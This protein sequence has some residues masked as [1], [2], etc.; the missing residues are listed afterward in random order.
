MLNAFL[1]GGFATLLATP[2]SAPFVGTAIGF[3]LARGPVEIV[4]VFAVMGLGLAAPYLAVAAFPGLVRLMPKP[5]RWMI[6]LRR[7]L[8][9]ALAG[10]ASWL[11][12]VMAANSGSDMA[13]L[14]G[15]AMV[16]VVILLAARRR[17]GERAPAARRLLG[18][19]AV[20]AIAAAFLGPWL[21][22]PRP[23]VQ[24]EMPTGWRAFDLT[25]LKRLVA[26]G[27][28][29]FVDVTA[30][31]CLTCKVNKALVLDREP[32]AGR[33]RQT[34][35]VAMRADWTKPDPLVTAYL[36]SFGR[37][38]VP[39]NAVY[40]PGAPQGIPLPELLT[41]DSVLGA[42]DKASRTDAVA[43]HDQSR[44]ASAP[45]PVNSGVGE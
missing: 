13:I 40:G 24:A 20:A 44:N 16:V 6:I 31:W 19:A 8:G 30:E 2:C 21:V 42:L 32:V 7:L 33:L 5:G 35:T 3:A 18:A 34:G 12:T 45:P 26:A 23:S 1:T 43:R 11:L 22:A 25:E 28:T 37:Y 27:Q 29:V 17:L 39:F 10:T 14:S 38:G 9:F 15:A 36:A 4:G 41:S